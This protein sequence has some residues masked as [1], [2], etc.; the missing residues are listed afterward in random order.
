MLAEWEGGSITWRDC[1]SCSKNQEDYSLWIWNKNIHLLLIWRLARLEFCSKIFRWKW[2]SSLL[3]NPA[4]EF[5]ALLF[6]LE[7][8]R[9]LCQNC[10]SYISVSHSKVLI[11]KGDNSVL[12]KTGGM[13]HCHSIHIILN[14]ILMRNWIEKPWDLESDCYRYF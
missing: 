3:F 7:F 12:G 14:N 1:I 9:V 10:L 4:I 11:S 5:F 13:E 2:H 6:S 8:W